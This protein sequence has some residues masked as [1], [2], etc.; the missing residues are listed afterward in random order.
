[1]KEKYRKSLDRL[2]LSKT[3]NDY[4]YNNVK[5]HLVLTG[6]RLYGGADIDS[7]YDYIIMKDELPPFL[8]DRIKYFTDGSHNDYCETVSFYLI[9]PDDPDRVLN[10]NVFQSKQEYAAWI[11]TTLTLQQLYETEH[12][13]LKELMVN[14]KQFRVRLFETI[15]VYEHN[16]IIKGIK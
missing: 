1:M 14:D 3:E 16:K 15:Y 11:K 12:S 9:D 7:D 10:I 6:S 13:I 2:N 8:Y 5:D 4:I